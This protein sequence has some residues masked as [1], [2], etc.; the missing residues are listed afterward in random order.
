MPRPHTLPTVKV[1]Y[2]HKG[3]LFLHI[4]PRYTYFVAQQGLKDS[5]CLIFGHFKPGIA[6]NETQPPSCE[7]WHTETT[8]PSHASRYHTPI[9]CIQR[10][11]PHHMH[12]ET[13][14]PSQA[15]R[16]HTPITCIQRPHTITCIQ[17]P[18]LYH[19]HT[20]GR[21]QHGILVTTMVSSTEV[22]LTHVHKHTQ[23][24]S[25]LLSTTCLQVLK[26]TLRVCVM[27]STSF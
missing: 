24:R 19:I 21:A 8:L 14:H 25:Y 3:Y 9:T 15:P 10:P 13:T 4:V 2:V 18:H 11:H 7:F 6:R 16:D 22:I 5:Q 20:G 1:E 17:R 23:P 26:M 27:N 12:P